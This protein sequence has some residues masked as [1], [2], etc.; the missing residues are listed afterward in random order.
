MEIIE[1]DTLHFSPIKY[2]YEEFDGT[3]Y[4]VYFAYNIDGTV[5]DVNNLQI[6]VTLNQNPISVTAEHCTH[7]DMLEQGNVYVIHVVLAPYYYSEGEDCNQSV[8]ISG[9]WKTEELPIDVPI[10]IQIVQIG[11]EE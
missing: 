5:I 4:H 10:S 11:C 2:S 9:G 6:T 3:N 8:N 7:P 1:N